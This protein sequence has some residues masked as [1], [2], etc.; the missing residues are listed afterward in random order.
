MHKAV[1]IFHLK[2]VHVIHHFFEESQFSS[3]ISSL[4]LI[5]TSNVFAVHAMFEFLLCRITVFLVLLA[6]ELV[7]HILL[8]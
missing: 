4:L 5:I 6:E 3:F 7:F 1:K 8:N 2:L